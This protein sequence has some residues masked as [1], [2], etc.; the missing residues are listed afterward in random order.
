MG[1][2]DLWSRS[3]K[4]TETQAACLCR[5]FQPELERIVSAT[6]AQV[7]M[8]DVNDYIGFG[9]FTKA[10]ETESPL[11]PISEA[12]VYLALNKWQEALDAL[13]RGM[14]LTEYELALPHLDNPRGVISD[15]LE[16]MEY[17]QANIR[18]PR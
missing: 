1:L 3:R 12:Q 8:F 17:A 11:S 16:R 18:P 10:K 14:R 15:L 6:P 13:N 5:M 4:L 9:I 2:F 7:H